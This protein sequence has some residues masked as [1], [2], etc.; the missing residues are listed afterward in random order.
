[1]SKPSTLPRHAVRHP[2]DDL[3]DHP[4]PPTLADHGYAP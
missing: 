1:M 2:R 3:P 4:S